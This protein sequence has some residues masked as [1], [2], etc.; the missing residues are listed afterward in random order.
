[1]E[2]PALCAAVFFGVIPG[3]PLGLVGVVVSLPFALFYGL[4]A[5]W[6]GFYGPVI[7]CGAG[8]YYLVGEIMLGIRAVFWE[9][10]CAFGRFL[11]LAF[12]NPKGRVNF[13]VS[14]ADHPKI[15]KA[16]RMELEEITWE[17]PKSPEEWR[18]WWGTHRDEFDKNM[19]RIKPPAPEPKPG[20]PR[21]PAPL[22]APEAPAP[23][24]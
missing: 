8:G 19:K 12:R 18:A 1:V 10:P 21:A 16:V 22:P 9:A 24:L 7:G 11:A 6:V 20:A 2:E 5:L 3:V 23:A 14:R 13:L 15:G 17:G 4:D